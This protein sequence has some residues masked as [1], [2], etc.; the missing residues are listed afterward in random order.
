VRFGRNVWGL[1]LSIPQPLIAAVHGYVLGS[2]IEMALCCD[3]RIASEDARFGLPEVGLGIIPAAGATQT[4]PRI[5]GRAKALEML[6]TPRWL[7]AE[8]AYR[9]GLVSKVVSREKLYETAEEMAQK[10]AS[11]HPM[12]VRSAKEAVVRG[13]DLPLAEGLDLEKS[14]IK[15]HE[16]LDVN[17]GSEDSGMLST[18]STVLSRIQGFEGS[19]IQGLFCEGFG[20]SASSLGAGTHEP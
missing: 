5:I 12:A 13:L 11:Y 19:R 9:F 20:S 10:M 4:L 6:L 8:E 17:G 18:L 2:G 15:N 16:S 7:N 14:C 3:I 1:F